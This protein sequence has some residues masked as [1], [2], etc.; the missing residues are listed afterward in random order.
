ME[1]QGTEGVRRLAVGGPGAGGV[2][3]H[4]FERLSNRNQSQ[5]GEDNLHQ[6]DGDADGHCHEEL[7]LVVVDF[8]NRFFVHTIGHPSFRLPVQI[9]YF[10]FFHQKLIL[11]DFFL[12]DDDVGHFFRFS[13]FLPRI[14]LVARLSSCCSCGGFEGGCLWPAIG[15][16]L[17][18]GLEGVG[19]G[20]GV[21]GEK[22]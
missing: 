21:G 7:D 17:I 5:E 3:R 19:A 1:A 11:F 20:A 6:D 15:R 18:R 14:F 22:S 2:D 4:D 9:S 13:R 16:E 8:R 12:S 10:R